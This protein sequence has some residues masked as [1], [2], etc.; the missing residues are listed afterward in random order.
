MIGVRHGQPPA[1]GPQRRQ[2]VLR[3]R[4]PLRRAGEHGPGG[5]VDG[6][7]GEPPAQPG[8]QAVRRQI[9][10]QHGPGSGLL[11]QPSP[12]RHQGQRILQRERARQAGRHVFAEAVAEESHGADPPIHP[13]AGESVLD[14]EQGGLRE[15]GPGQRGFGSGVEEQPDV[16]AEVG[17]QQLRATVHLR[18]ERRLAAIELGSHARRLRPLPGEHEG[19]ARLPPPP[20]GQSSGLGSGQAPRRLQ[21]IAG[22]HREPVLVPAA[23]HLQRVGSVGQ[24]SFGVRFQAPRQLLRGHR[25]SAFRPGGQHGELPVPPGL[26][27]LPGRRLLEHHVHVGAADP[28]GADPRAPGDPR[29]LPGLHLGIDVER[30]LVEA[31]PGV[32]TAEAHGGWN[33]AV[34]EGQHRLQQAGHPRRGVEVPEVPLHR[35]QGAAP[36]PGAAAEDLP[37]GLHLRRI[38]QGGA[39]A[40]GLDVGDGVRLH[41]GGRQRLGDDLRLAVDAR[42]RETDLGGA[43]V[44]HRGAP[45]H[46]PDEIAVRQ[47]VLVA[48]Q[49]DHAG[50]VAVHHALARLIERPSMAVRGMDPLGL[51]EVAL[52]L[53]HAD[54]HPAGH[55]HVALETEEALAGEMDGGQRAGAGA[56]DADAG[57]L[58]VQQVGGP[59]GHEVLLVAQEDLEGLG[60]GEPLRRPGEDVDQV[61]VEPGAGENA[62]PRLRR[63]DAPTRG[64][65]GFPGAL[66]EEAVLRIDQ[67]GLAGGKPEERGVEQLAAH[68]HSPG[69]DVAGVPPELL[70]NAGVHQVL[71]AEP[72][73]G[74]GPGDEVAPEALGVR[75][76]GEAQGEADDGDAGER[77]PSVAAAH[78]SSLPDAGCRSRA[79]AWA[80]SRRRPRSPARPSAAG[81]SS[82]GEETKRAWAST[83]VWRRRST[84]E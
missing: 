19:H 9:D 60:A 27:G 50:A 2:L 29:R 21:G 55:G 5:A 10:R 68:H 47:R 46:R 4:H 48:L 32:G 62:R 51:V 43:V 74:I 61:A 57:P 17:A 76:A 11:H 30:P 81:R 82:G 67:L 8:L 65:Q 66:Q 40:V 54:R 6:R 78:R 25:Q 16:G 22:D 41:T 38:A 28:E 20:A 33:P 56:V 63:P 42:R 3:R 14:H 44:V 23:A 53:G 58:E 37:Q 77:L 64:L 80:A 18:A 79:P 13:Q 72:G 39:R 7:E 35:A 49:Q 31:Q 15:V 71:R 45:D 84:T 70:R 36:G 24:G 75:G 12:G 34:P 1:G 83:V 26:R 52:L 59:G 73:H 69:R